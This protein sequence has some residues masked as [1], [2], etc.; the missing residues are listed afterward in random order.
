MQGISGNGFYLAVSC[1][2]EGGQ[3]WSQ[4]AEVTRTNHAL[5]ESYLLL[6]SC[7]MP[8]YRLYR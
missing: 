8:A 7:H 2:P 3:L 5:L 6:Q 1:G 4:M